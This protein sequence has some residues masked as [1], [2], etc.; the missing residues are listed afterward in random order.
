MHSSLILNKKRDTYEKAL[1]MQ[2]FC[3]MSAKKLTQFSYHYYTSKNNSYFTYT[4]TERLFTIFIQCMK[5]SESSA[6]FFRASFIFNLS[7][8][9]TIPPK[10]LLQ[11]IRR[12]FCKQT[13]CMMRC[14]WTLFILATGISVNSASSSFASDNTSPSLHYREDP[15]SPFVRQNQHHGPQFRVVPLMVPP[16]PSL[17]SSSTSTASLD[18][19][20]G[21]QS[22][23][24][25]GQVDA[26]GNVCTATDVRAQRIPFMPS[27]ASQYNRNNSDI[28]SF[29]TS[30]I[31]LSRAMLNFDQVEN[32]NEDLQFTITEMAAE[33]LQAS[34]ATT[35]AAVK[36]AKS[37]SLINLYTHHLEK[38]P[39]FNKVLTAGIIGIMGDA[40]SQYFEIAVMGKHRAGSFTS[41]FDPRRNLGVFLEGFL[42]SGPLMHYSYNL[43][44]KILPI[45]ETNGVMGSI[46]AG[47]QVFLD[48]FIMDPFYVLSAMITGGLFEGFSFTNDLIPQIS[49]DFFPSMKAA[50]ISSFMLSPIQFMAFRCLPVNLRSLAMNVQNII[51]N[52]VVLYM[53]HR[54]RKSFHI[55]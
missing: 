39:L 8:I 20:V 38:Y 40:L 50:W 45:S 46:F 53:A 52:A 12:F 26:S 33:K 51:W 21:L 36:S 5:K 6:F 41:S 2:S 27:S 48:C 16:P 7:L 9:H 55:I 32:E 1:I 37:F 29:D 4:R 42:I 30:Q 43:F 24:N 15:P 31:P 3:S 25:L 44:E 47:M 23:D 17:Q 54:G 18:Q 19:D 10:N 28:S 49:T 35:T 22:D 13:Y 11:Y 14:Q 34:S